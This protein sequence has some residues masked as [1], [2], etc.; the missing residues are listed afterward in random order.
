VLTKM[1][2]IGSFVTSEALGG[3]RRSRSKFVMEGIRREGAVRSWPPWVA[4]RLS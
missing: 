3:E 2:Q 4:L 1:S